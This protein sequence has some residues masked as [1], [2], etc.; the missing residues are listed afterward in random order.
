MPKIQFDVLV[1]DSDAIDLAGRFSVVA[2]LI[3][4]KGL[5]DSGLVIHDPEAKIHEFIDSQLRQ[6]YR[7]EHEDADMENAS[8]NRYL[9]EVDG[10]KGSINQITMIFS[11]LLTPPA[12]LPKDAF[13]LEQELAYEIPAVYPWTVEII[14]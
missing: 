10:V 2:K 7:D 13:L 14:R 11:R 3:V 4:E 6:T 5:M 9:I 12:E 1:P 8:V